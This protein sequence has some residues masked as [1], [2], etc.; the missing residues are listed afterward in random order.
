MK[1]TIRKAIPDD[2]DQVAQLWQE[3][4]RYHLQYSPCFEI[5]DRAAIDFSD[6]LRKL[7]NEPSDL[8]LLAESNGYV[9][10]FLHGSILK[11]PPCFVIP[12]QGQIWD[13]FVSE[14]FRRQGV[15]RE[16]VDRALEFF[17]EKGMKFVDVRITTQNNTALAFWKK[18][19]IDPYITVGKLEP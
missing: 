8:L 3:L 15:A 11:R 17:R 1:V 10:G 7:P 18:M 16:L 19:G 9:V 2:A 13:L 4:L 5:S 12:Q 14:P 6:H